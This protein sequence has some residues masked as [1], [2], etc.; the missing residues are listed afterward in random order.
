MHAGR[1]PTGMRGD[2]GEME[3]QDSLAEEPEAKANVCA[4]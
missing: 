2:Y 3:R 4:G 1:A